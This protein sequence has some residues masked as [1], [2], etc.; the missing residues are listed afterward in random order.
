MDNQ[1]T[2]RLEFIDLAKGLCIMLVVFQHVTSTFGVSDYPFK[3]GLASFR[4]PLYFFLS[5][6]FF[7]SYSGF[8]EFLEKKFNKLFIPFVFFFLTTSCTLPYL[9]AYF[10]LRSFPKSDIWLSFFFQESFPNIPIWFLLGLFFVNLIFYALYILAHQC[11]H[12]NW[13]RYLILFS[14]LVGFVGCLLGY[15][16]INLP[17]FLD[18]AMTALPF[19]LCG[20]LIYRYTPL[21]FPNKLDK[22]NLVFAISLLAVP[23]IFCNESVH[24]LEN[25]ISMSVF[26]MYAY[27][28]SG[29]L[30]ILLLSKKIN[31]L[32]LVS[33]FGRYSII[34][35]L[36][37]GWIL[38]V[39]IKIYHSLSFT[40]N[41]MLAVV[42][43][44]TLTMFSYLA[45]I[46]ICKKIIPWFCA[47]KD[48]V[49]FRKIFFK[50]HT[51]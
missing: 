50:N 19:F 6:L 27:G 36:T 13:M 44:F 33:Y 5:G 18:S 3:L 49:S 1:K 11:F 43:I 40:L 22:W 48:L 16:Q 8:L 31:K 51:F 4:M 26:A 46:P 9:L 10:N 14:I 7:K 37:H 12:K 29:T 25:K 21:V 30:G 20:F 32:P 2:N 45:V 15:K 28:L 23:L 39:C 38:W 41:P 24:Y 17:M 42:L 34:I 47:Q 35:L